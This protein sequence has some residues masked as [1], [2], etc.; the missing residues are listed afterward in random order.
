[1]IDH[2]VSVCPIDVKIE[3]KIEIVSHHGMPRNHTFG[4]DIILCC[5]FENTSATSCVKSRSFLC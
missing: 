4:F 3:M 5:I 1:M 2:A